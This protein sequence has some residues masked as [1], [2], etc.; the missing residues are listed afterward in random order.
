MVTTI[1]TRGPISSFFLKMQRERVWNLVEFGW[2]LP[3]KLDGTRD[4]LEN[5]I[6]KKIGQ[7]RQ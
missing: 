6:P 5:S 7:T 1:H 3:L 4:Q 2:G